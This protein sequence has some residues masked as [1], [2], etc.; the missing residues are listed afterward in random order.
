MNRAK[1]HLVVS[2]RLDLQYNEIVG[3]EYNMLYRLVYKE[4]GKKRYKK[5][6]WETMDTRVQLSPMI[7][8]LRNNIFEDWFL[9]YK[10]EA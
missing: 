1:L 2:N 4:K 9:E 7:Y 5:S 6:A 8:K 3:G 10:Q